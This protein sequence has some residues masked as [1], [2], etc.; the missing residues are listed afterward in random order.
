MLRRQLRLGTLSQPQAR[1]ALED[2]LALPVTVYPTAPVLVRCWQL[3]DNV[4]PYDACYIAL[5]ESL[6]CALVTADA[7]L[8]GAPG[9][10]CPIEVI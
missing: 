5:A 7:R 3:R 8:A 6:D 4:V 2:L 1:R 9:P 10:T